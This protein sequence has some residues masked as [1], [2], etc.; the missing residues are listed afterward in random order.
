M[1]FTITR[2]I[3]VQVAACEG[4]M[5][6]VLSTAG[7]SRAGVSTAM[8][9]HTIRAAAVRRRDLGAGTH[10]GLNSGEQAAVPK[11]IF[12]G[13]LS[14]VPRCALKSSFLANFCIAL[15]MRVSP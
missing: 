1:I 7:A 5:I 14:R 13:F 3:S 8:G 10:N 4:G 11:E 6:G 9:R 2:T 12:G 15:A